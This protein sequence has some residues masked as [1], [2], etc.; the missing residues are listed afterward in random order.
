MRTGR[1]TALAA[2]WLGMLAGAPARGG[3]NSWWREYTPLATVGLGAPHLDTIQPGAARGAGIF[4][5]YGFW[6]VDEVSRNRVYEATRAKLD[7]AGV[8]RVIYYDLGEVGDYAGFFTPD[9]RMAHSG[10][11]LPWWKGQEELQARW[12]GLDAFMR[13]VEWAP[14]PTA[15]AYGLPAFTQPD[16]S[17]AADLYAT[18]SR[19]GLDGAWDFDFSSNGRITDEQAERSG[20]AKLSGKQSARAEVQ[21]KNGWQTVRLVSVDFANPQFRDYVC[22]EIERII[23]LVRPEG[24]HGDNFGDNNLGHANQ[25]AFGQWSVHRF[26]EYLASHFSK[27][28]LQAMGVADAA[29]FDI[30]AYI[31]DKPFPSR[32]KA[33]HPQ[34]PEWAKDPVWASYRMHLVESAQAFHRA[35]YG[36]AKRAAA[37]AGLD[38]AVFGNSIPFPLG[39]TLLKGACDVAHFEWSTVHGWY[40]MRPLGLPPRGRLGYVTRLGAAMSDAGYCWPSLYVSKDKSGPGHENLHKILAFD[41]FANRGLLDFG[42]W[43]LDGYS[44]GTPESAGFVNGFIREHAARLSKR[45]YLADVALIHSGWSEV[46]SSTVFNPV[47]DQF[48]DE[49]CGWCQFLGDTHRQWEVVLQQDLT[50]EN[51]SR[52]PVVVLPSVLCLSD[53]HLTE[54]RRYVAKGGRLVATGQ[55][56]ERFGPE[57]FLRARGGAGWR[58]EGARMS[59]GKP[60][61]RYWRKE[62]EPEAA[63]EM[64]DLLTFDGLQPRL[65]TD[66]PATTGVNANLGND[67]NGEL[68]SL[69]LNN[70]DI[71]AETDV[72]RGA[73]S[74]CTTLRL[75]EHWSASAVSV[76][77]LSPGKA[78][79]L[80]PADQW[81]L[82]ANAQTLRIQSP[83]FDTLLILCIRPAGK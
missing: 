69:D 62:R 34:N 9:G 41:A 67:A 81:E 21:G 25:S 23:P 82:D 19:R 57:Q 66:A 7:Q 53:A 43:Y 78:G 32:G 8:R 59:T 75:P 17:P 24:I 20:L 49:Y 76:S 77:W 71:D 65:R 68:L 60:G 45:R 47:M 55:T 39:G 16:G 70:C 6:Y 79:A 10:W 48:V 33:W 50:A 4:G 5:W 83:P 22:R 61:V 44:P 64:A 35:F 30:T 1:R 73:P 80:L 12:F 26:R 52:F 3:D 29:S 13:D 42:H 56:G 37:K 28:E 51:L 36:S 63:R 11:S 2:L 15:K 27:E 40:G 72:I 54:L 18:L 74:F 31:R 58:I 14:H 46:A 38:C